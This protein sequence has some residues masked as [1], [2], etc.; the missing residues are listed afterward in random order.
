[1]RSNSHKLE[2]G[3][4]RLDVRKNIMWMTKE[5]YRL[6]KDTDESPAFQ[7]LN[8]QLYKNLNIYNRTNFK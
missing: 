4:F 7:T 5:G 2:H 3:K 8:A 1:M 6:C